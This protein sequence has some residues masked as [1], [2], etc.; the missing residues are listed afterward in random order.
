MFKSQYDT[1]MTKV[2]E[3]A[4]FKLEEYDLEKQI[5]FEVETVLRVETCILMR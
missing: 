1:I 2:L 3:L 4:P 5:S